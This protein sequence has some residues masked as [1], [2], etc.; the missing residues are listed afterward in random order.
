MRSLIKIAL[1]LALSVAA[2]RAVYVAADPEKRDID[3]AVRASAPGQFVRLSDGYTHFEVGGPPDG[4]VVVLAAGVSVP[5]YIWDPDVRGARRRRLPRAALRLLRPR[6]FG[7]A[8]HRVHA[9]RS[10][11]G[12]SPSCST[13]CTSRSRSI[14]PVSRSAGRWSPA[15]PIA[16]RPRVRSLVFIDPSFRSPY[17]VGFVGAAAEAVGCADRD[18][19]RALV[20]RPAAGGFLPSGTVPGLAQSLRGA[21]PVSR[22]PARPAIDGG[23]QCDRGSG[24]AAETGWRA[25]STGAGVLGQGGYRG[26]ARIQRHA[27][28]GDAPRPSGGGR[29]RPAICHTGSSRTSSIP[30]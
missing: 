16:I 22:L 18:L 14:S 20:G 3:Q 19:R 6:L 7:P 26:A 11:C 12:S 2:G 21:D 9:G 17:S 24:T 15:L 4:P 25:P 13:P 10:T 1:S 30:S 8:G 28:G 27:A 29:D 5:Y 23:E